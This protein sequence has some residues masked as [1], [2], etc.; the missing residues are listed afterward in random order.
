MSRKRIALGGMKQAIHIWGT[1]DANPVV[2]FLHGGPGA[3][4][5]EGIQATALVACLFVSCALFIY[6]YNDKEIVNAIRRHNEK[7][8]V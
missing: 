8:K 6:F 3:A 5:S 1:Q 7:T 4:T 2:L